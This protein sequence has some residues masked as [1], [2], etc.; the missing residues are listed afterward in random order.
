MI[1]YKNCGVL[2]SQGSTMIQPVFKKKQKFDNKK[3]LLDRVESHLS[4]PIQLS[5]IPI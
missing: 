1:Q 3:D 5:L 4:L 2:R